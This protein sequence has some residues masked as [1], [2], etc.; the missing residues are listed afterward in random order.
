MKRRIVDYGA[1]FLLACSTL[2]VRA[3]LPSDCKPPAAAA[4]AP[5][6]T[7]PAKIDEAVGA[8]FAQKG[9]LDC[10]ASAF[11]QA[12]RLEPRSAAAHF[13]LG[14]IRQRQQQPATAIK[15]FELALQ[16]EPGL[17]PA[18]C[19]LGWA[20]QDPVRAKQEFHEALAA[21]PH[22]VC[23]LN[24]MAQVLAEQKHYDAAVRYWRQAVKLQPDEPGMQLSLAT[25]IYK[26]AQLTARGAS[27]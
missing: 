13:D 17:L 4:N 19:A 1:L 21:N 7:S 8:W 2:P 16:Y 12:L 5:A 26:A 18:R 20:L 25:A 6:G 9:D 15:E 10:S 22:L 3:Q 27:A 11:E 14:L 24:G 23:A